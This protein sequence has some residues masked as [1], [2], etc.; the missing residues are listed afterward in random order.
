M[1]VRLYVGNLSFQLTADE[2]GAAFARVV[3]VESVH[4][5]VDRLT[6]RPRGFGFVEIADGADAEAVIDALN[7]EPLLGRPIVVHHARPRE[8]HGHDDRRRDAHPS[9]ARGPRP[10]FDRG[11]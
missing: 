5:P 6:G 7:G 3:P 1:S 11:R 8:Q 4:V 2:V 10:H 9:H